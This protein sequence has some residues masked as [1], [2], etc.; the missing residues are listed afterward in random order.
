[1]DEIQPDY[2]VVIVGGGAAGLAAY[3]TAVSQSFLTVLLE[4]ES[5]LGGTTIFAIGSMTAARTQLQNK[6]GIEDS[7]D[8]FFE[9]LIVASRTRGVEQ[10]CD[11]SL[12]RLYAEEAGK[13]LDWLNELG[14]VFVGPFPESPHRVPRMHNAVPSAYSFVHRLEGFGTKHGGKILKSYKVSK[15][16]QD[17]EGR[18]AGVSG[19]TI[20]GEP[21]HFKARK[22][23]IIATGPYSSNQEILKEL[24]PG[25]IEAEPVNPTATG[26]GISLCRKIGA[27]TKN[28]EIETTQF[29]FGGRTTG[30][31]GKVATWGV[32]PQII[33]WVVEHFPRSFTNQIIVRLSTTYTAPSDKILLEGGILIDGNGSRF[34]NELARPYPYAIAKKA[35]SL[36]RKDLYL[37]FDSSTAAKLVKWPNY[38][39]TFPGIA[40]AYLDDYLKFRKDVIH[41]SYSFETLAWKSNLSPEILKATVDR[42]NSFAAVHED[43]DFGREQLRPIESPPF[44][45]LGPI[46]PVI[47]VTEGGIAINEKCQALNVRGEVIR[48]LYVIGDGSAGP[49]NVSHGM[50]LGWALTSGRLSVLSILRES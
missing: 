8:A 46:R 9:D 7:T 1:M 49:L 16:V 36:I 43:R 17:D 24:I 48:G 34:V 19:H 26:D 4:K 21:F 30:K 28:T 44:Y 27:W 12:L 33:G 31:I 18:V 3:A 42:Y 14:V 38:V 25:F 41:K 13:T 47:T 29:R 37:L 32:L 35:T 5:D 2:D 20:L 11:K 6:R 40:Y 15:L 23:V 39:S 45:L 10:I 22:G 50:H